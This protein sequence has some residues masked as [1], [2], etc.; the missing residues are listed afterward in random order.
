M[1]LKRRI[2]LVLAMA[3]ALSLTVGLALLTAS[4]QSVTLSQ[5]DMVAALQ[6]ANGQAQAFDGG[7]YRAYYGIP[8][9]TE[10]QPMMMDNYI[11]KICNL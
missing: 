10:I 1:R 4:A 6:E 7:T 5:A 2:C 3:F 11:V 9:A 8:G